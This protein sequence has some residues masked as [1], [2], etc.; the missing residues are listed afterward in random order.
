[1]PTIAIFRV[2]ASASCL[3]HIFGIF[4]LNEKLIHSVQQYE[5][6]GLS[7]GNPDYNQPIGRD[8]LG[9]VR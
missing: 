6:G 5:L 1:M 4:L 2:A 7:V 9:K 8:D 3:L